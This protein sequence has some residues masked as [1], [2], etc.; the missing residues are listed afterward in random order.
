ML[1]LARYATGSSWREYNNRVAL[2]SGQQATYSR[3]MVSKI[4]KHVLTGS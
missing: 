3:L 2:S 1:D 4:G